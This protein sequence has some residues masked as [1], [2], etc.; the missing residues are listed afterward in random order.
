MTVLIWILHAFVFIPV[1]IGVYLYYMGSTGKAD[2]TTHG[3]IVVISLSFL[4]F[5]LAIFFGIVLVVVK[6]FTGL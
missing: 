6:I 4:M 5:G 3:N 1:L 2:P